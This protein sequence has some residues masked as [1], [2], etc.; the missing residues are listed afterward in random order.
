MKRVGLLPFWLFCGSSSVLT[1][2]ELLVYFSLPLR[3]VGLHVLKEG[4]ERLSGGQ[5]HCA[6]EPS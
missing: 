2:R 1:N 4:K 3:L 6:D 5:V